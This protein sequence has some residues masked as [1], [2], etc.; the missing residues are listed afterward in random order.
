MYLLSSFE[1]VLSIHFFTLNLT[2]SL[3]QTS[4]KFAKLSMD[5]TSTSAYLSAVQYNGSR[6]P[7][8]LSLDDFSKSLGVVLAMIFP[9]LKR[10]TLS[11]VSSNDSSNRCSTI[12]IVD[13]VSS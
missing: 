12:I 6:I 7:A 2:C 8:S 5:S 9:S 4:R 13:F 3:I 10:R 11:N 1:D